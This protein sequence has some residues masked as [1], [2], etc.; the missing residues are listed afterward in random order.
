MQAALRNI[1]LACGRVI[2]GARTEIDLPRV[3]VRMI[4]VGA[5]MG[6]RKALTHSVLVLTRAAGDHRHR[7]EAL[8]RQSDCQ[9]DDQSET[10]KTLHV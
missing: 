3:R 1:R 10:N 6:M 8:H 4:Y 7:S 9:Q 2:D 5:G